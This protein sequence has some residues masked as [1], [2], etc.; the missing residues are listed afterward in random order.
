MNLL[1]KLLNWDRSGMGRWYVVPLC[2][3]SPC[4]SMKS[5][6]Q[7]NNF[8]TFAFSSLNPIHT[9]PPDPLHRFSFEQRRPT[10]TQRPG[11]RP[12]STPPPLVT[13]RPAR[14]RSAGNDRSQSPLV[15]FVSASTRDSV[16]DPL[17]ERIAVSS[18]LSPGRGLL[19]RMRRDFRPSSSAPL[20]NK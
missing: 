10:G 11:R 9:A 8:C 16:G 19:R 4:K 3:F 20:S 7:S 17:H 15:L 14:T 1:S 18:I 2:H 6:L 13:R 12:T 5:N